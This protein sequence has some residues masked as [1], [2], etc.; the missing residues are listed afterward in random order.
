M[1]IIIS[2]PNITCSIEEIIVAS[3][4]PWKTLLPTL[5]NK[6]GKSKI[7]AAPIKATF[8]VPSPPKIHMNNILKDNLIS[9]ATGSTNAINVVKAVEFGLKKLR[10]PLVVSRQRGISLKNLFE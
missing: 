10:D 2:K 7:N 5:F 4:A 6:T 3:I 8:M 1:K 9:K